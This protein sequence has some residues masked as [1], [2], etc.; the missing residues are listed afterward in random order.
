M[1]EACGASGEIGMLRRANVAQEEE[2]QRM[3]NQSAN[4]RGSWNLLG[5]RRIKMKYKRTS[6][7]GIITKSSLRILDTIEHDVDFHHM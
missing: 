3:E 6:V 7:I 2:I 1:V 4:F 5:R